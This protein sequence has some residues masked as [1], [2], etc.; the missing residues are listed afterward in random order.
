MKNTNKT[1]FFIE[2][3]T[4][5]L[6]IYRNWLQREGFKVESAVD[7]LTAVEKLP[8]LKPDLVILD[9]MLPKLN[10]IDVLQFIRERADL[11]D[12]PVLVLSNAYMDER[13]SKASTV[14]ANKRLLK[15]QCTSAK[16][17]E[18]VRELL[19]AGSQPSSAKDNEESFQETRAGLLK[20]APGEIAKIREFCLAFVKTVGSPENT[21]HLNNLYQRIR[22][23]CARAGLGDCTKIAHLASALEAMLF[24]IIFK[25]P[26]PSTSALQTIAQSVDCLGRLFQSEDVQSA[27]AMFKARV[28]IVDD[29]PICTFA[30][31]AAMKRARLEAVSAQDPIAALEL[32]EHEHYDIVLLD[33]SMPGMNG[34]ELCKKLRVLSGYQKTPVVFITSNSEFQNRAQAI[35]SGGN[36]LIAKPI[37]PLEL[38]LKIIDTFDRAAR[39]AGYS[40]V[41]NR[42]KGNSVHCFA[43]Y[44]NRYGKDRDA[45]KTQDGL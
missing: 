8:K 42:S 26:K 34:F 9:W 18:E 45:N 22:F 27:E 17:I 30:T 37:S 23:L 28:L 1:I 35:L 31:V 36:D 44:A 40:Q 24:E 43:S 33:I 6:T 14:G 5:V 20:D 4:L 32:A 11:K 15:T 25:N 10:G 19:G 39:T 38:A 2:D 21:E 41:Q 29:D 3:N 12:T 16:L 13:A 7:G